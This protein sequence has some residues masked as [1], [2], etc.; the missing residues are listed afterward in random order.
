MDSDDI[1]TALP[2]LSV[3]QSFSPVCF[4]QE[5]ETPAGRWQLYRMP[6]PRQPDHQNSWAV[7]Q[8]WLHHFFPRNTHTQCQSGVRFS[9]SFADIMNI[10]C[11]QLICNAQWHTEILELSWGEVNYESLQS[12]NSSALF[13]WVFDIDRSTEHQTAAP[14]GQIGQTLQTISV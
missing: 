2:F 13:Y 8:L 7:S 6:F 14:Q 4:D 11:T 1:S 10:S 9:L 3:T 5:V 12:P